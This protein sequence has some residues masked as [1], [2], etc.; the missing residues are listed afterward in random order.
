MWDFLRFS[1]RL[2]FFLIP[3]TECNWNNACICMYFSGRDGVFELRVRYAA[4]HTQK[5]TSDEDLA[6]WPSLLNADASKE[7]EMWNFHIKKF[8]KPFK[9]RIKTLSTIFSVAQSH[10]FSNV[11][12]YLFTKQWVIR[13]MCRRRENVP[14]QQGNVKRHFQNTI[15][16]LETLMFASVL[17]VVKINTLKR[18]AC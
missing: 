15:K 14:N 17:N 6:F 8:Y 18:A 16:I 10:G 7:P 9:R 12:T 3:K 1:H 5:Y 13:S 4:V 2:S 11:L